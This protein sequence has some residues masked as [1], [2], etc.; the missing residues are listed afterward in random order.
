MRGPWT[1]YEIGCRVEFGEMPFTM[2]PA[3]CRIGRSHYFPGGSIQ[4]DDEI[5]EKPVTTMLMM[6]EDSTIALVTGASR[7]IGLA[8]AKRWSVVAIA[9]AAAQSE[10]LEAMAGVVPISLDVTDANAVADVVSHIELEIGPIDLL[11]NNAGAAGG[12]GPTWMHEPREWWQVFEVNVLGPF[13]CCHSVVPKMISRGRGRI[14]NMSSNAG[15]FRIDDGFDLD[16]NSAY[17]TSKAA[18]IRFSEVL[19]EEVRSRGVSVFAMSPGTVK[20]DMTAVPFADH[21]D[22]PDLW[23]P[24]ELAAELV[25]FIATGA[26]DGLSGRYIHAVSDDWRSLGGRTAEIVDNDSKVLR[27]TSVPTT[28]DQ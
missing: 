18:I 24:P 11:V 3:V 10:E 1:L 22:D 23:S 4:N 25:E 2:A 6:R 7:G 9:R 15:F 16:I 8:I 21:W 20:T 13:H 19:A 17:M 14:I 28:E 26:L 5:R 27:L 12:G